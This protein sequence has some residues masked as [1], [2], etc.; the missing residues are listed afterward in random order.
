MFSVVKWLQLLWY[1][2]LL[3]KNEG[4]LPLCD[5]FKNV[6]FCEPDMGCLLQCELFDVFDFIGKNFLLFGVLAL[7]K[8]VTKFFKF[9][10]YIFWAIF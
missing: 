5:F 1:E 3:R 9:S 2:T 10:R 7:Y 8:K 4:K 6:K